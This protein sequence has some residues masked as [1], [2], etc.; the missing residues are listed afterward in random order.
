MTSHLGVSVIIPT[1]Q[2]AHELPTAVNSALRQCV[3]NLDVEVIVVDD[4]ST[5]DTAG[6]LEAINDDRLTVVVQERKGRCAA[7]NAGAR[8]A[9]HDWYIFLDSDDEMAPGA[10]ASFAPCLSSDHSLVLAPT[11]RRASDGETTVGEIQWDEGR[12]LPWGLQAGAFAI[13]RQLFEAIGGYCTELHYS[14]HTEMAFRLR[15]I[16]QPPSIRKLATPTVTVNVRIGRY[17]PRVQYET[18]THLLEHVSEQMALDRN[19]RAIYLR[20]AGEAASQLGQ[21]AESIALLRRSFVAQPSIGTLGRSVRA[22]GRS[23]RPPR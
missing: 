3:A 2:R 7:R 9:H 8:V 4:G 6:V 23:I 17:D 18:A 15:D 12:H 11:D 21:T 1:Y 20:I 14:E 22:L 5:D 13:H 19:A 10:L 16:R